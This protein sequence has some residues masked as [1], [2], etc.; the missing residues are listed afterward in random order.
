MFAWPRWLPTIHRLNL[1]QVGAFGFAVKHSLRID[2]PQLRVNT[3]VLVVPTAILQQ[4]VGDLGGG[5]QTQL[6][7]GAGAETQ[8][9]SANWHSKKKHILDNQ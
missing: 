7:R 1:Q 8:V 6:Y 9:I 2:E 4:G 5:Q 3:E